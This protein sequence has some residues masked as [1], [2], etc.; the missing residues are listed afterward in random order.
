MLF[1]SSFFHHYLYV[2]RFCCITVS[3]FH[4]LFPFLFPSSSL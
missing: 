1:F 2:L 3:V 4:H